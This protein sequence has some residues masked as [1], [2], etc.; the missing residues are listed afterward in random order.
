MCYNYYLNY[1]HSIQQ[2]IEFAYHQF[3][4]SNQQ[5]FSITISNFTQFTAHHH[6]FSL[7]HSH[8]HMY[9][10]LRKADLVHFAE[11]MDAASVCDSVRTTPFTD[12]F[13]RICLAE[14]AVRKDE[15]IST[16]FEQRAYDERAPWSFLHLSDLSLLD[17][18]STYKIPPPERVELVIEAYGSDFIEV[19]KSLLLTN[20]YHS[21]QL[22]ATLFRGDSQ[23]GLLPPNNQ[24]IKDNNKTG[25]DTKAVHET[26]QASRRTLE[27]HKKNLKSATVDEQTALQADVK[28]KAALDLYVELRSHKFIRRWTLWLNNPSK[29][30]QDITK[31]ICHNLYY[32]EQPCVVIRQIQAYHVRSKEPIF[33]FYTIKNPAHVIPQ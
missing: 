29:N 24:V 10:Q 19:G 11:N 31:T 25:L 33:H 26:V 15:S 4:Y 28:A 17:P 6:Y 9:A 13:G 18:K 3:N 7:L 21:L 22:T 30:W 23:H 32:S 16:Q 12:F 20:R 1:A 14:I 5:L 27:K 2:F 8:T